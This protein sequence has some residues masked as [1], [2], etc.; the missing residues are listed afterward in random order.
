MNEEWARFLICKVLA[1]EIIIVSP[2][3]L[4]QI[5]DEYSMK[6]HAPFGLHLAAT[7]ALLKPMFN[8]FRDQSLSN[9]LHL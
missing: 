1:S 5:S 8:L 6:I 4:E 7:Y 2:V 3:C 9:S